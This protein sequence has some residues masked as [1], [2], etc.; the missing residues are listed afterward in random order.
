MIKVLIVVAAVFSTATLAQVK[1]V[2]TQRLATT[3][4]VKGAPTS[5]TLQCAEDDSISGCIQPASERGGLALQE[6][7]TPLSG[8]YDPQ[9]SRK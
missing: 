6:S 7:Y 2:S 5:W 4:E 9:G 1:A 3:A 8:I